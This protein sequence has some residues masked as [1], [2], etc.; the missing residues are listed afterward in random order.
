TISSA[1]NHKTGD[2][3]DSGRSHRG[4]LGDIAHRDR[5]HEEVARYVEATGDDGNAYE[6]SPRDQ[7]LIVLPGIYQARFT[8]KNLFILM[9]SGKEEKFQLIQVAKL[10]K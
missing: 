3:T 8:D 6:I 7:K 1:E 5:H 10:A 9:P 4:V 2:S